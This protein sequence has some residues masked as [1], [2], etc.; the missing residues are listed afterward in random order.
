[1][2]KQ[3][4][5]KAF[6]LLAFVFTLSITAPMAVVK[7]Q[8]T[9]YVYGD[10]NGDGTVNAADVLLLRKYM[11]NYNYDTGE[12]TVVLGPPSQSCKHILVTDP[13]VEP[14]FTTTGLTEGSHCGLCGIVFVAQN[15][16]PV[17]PSK[18]TLTSDTLSIEGENINGNV[19]YATD[20]FVF[21]NNITVTNN[22]SWTV[23]T[24]IYGMQT[25]TTKIVPLNEG[26]NIFYIHITNPDQTVSI[27]N[28]NIYRNHLYTVSFNTNGGTSVSTQYVEEGYL[29]KEPSTSRT[30]YTFVSWD[31]NF[32][33]PITS[34]VTINA[35]WEANKNTP[36]VVEYYLQN[37]EDDNYSIASDETEELTGTTD[38]I[39]TAREKTFSHFTYNPSKSTMSGN[40]DGDGS[41][42][43]KVYYTK[44][45]YT[46]SSA[47]TKGGS[48]IGSGTY[49]Y[50]TTLTVSAN[51]NIGYTFVGWYN[52]EN[53]IST[54]NSYT[55]TIDK[56]IDIEA[57]FDVK[58][59]MK[60][61]A[62]S[63]TSTTCTITGVK[64]KSI[65]EL[66][67][68]D[69]VTSIS[70]SALSGCSSLES[71]TLPFVGEKKDGTG[72]THF[73]YIF[74]ASSYS[75]NDSY[76]PKSLKT[77]VITGGTSIGDDAFYFCS[78]LTSVYI[79]DLVKWCE[80][81]FSDSS[82]NPFY[83]ANNLYLN[84]ELVTELVIPDSI[85]SINKY[86]FYNCSSLTS[87]TIHDG[88]T[89]IGYEAFYGCGL[90]SIEVES[91]NAKYHSAG[92][93]LIETDSRTLILGSNNSTIPSDGSVKRIGSYAFY[94][95][96][97]LTS[98]TIPDS[99]TS[100][101]DD[102]FYGC[103][104]LTSVTIGNGVTSIGDDAFY[105]CRSLESITLP[106]VGEKKDGTG[107]THFGYIFGASDY[108]YNSSYVPKS[109]K[110]VVITG[111]TSI[112]NRAFSDCSSLT[113]VTIGNGVTSIGYKAFD[114]CSR[115][116]SITFEDTSTWYRTTSSSDWKN[117]TGGTSTN[118]TNPSFSATYFT[119]TSYYYNYYWYKK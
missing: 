78:S 84:G 113:S 86:A 92:N 88:V 65:T 41:L 69:Y 22:S 106:F 44:D 118:V 100:I 49:K 47:N 101:G 97:N 63:S 19:S 71:I 18:A 111:G 15:I 66:V 35:N 90:T 76:V 64:D 95:C 37:L 60:I 6:L 11:A 36:Y 17:L 58:D 1:M 80:F 68:P 10:A 117:K 25:I 50:G 61:F 102:A 14:T 12:S 112:G 99:V 29:A 2:K 38:T 89:S 81:S 53:L 74:G 48:V 103:S 108:S 70:K 30:G 98:I 20:I 114:G 23:S 54:N 107:N 75:Y 56:D 21:A 116:T 73:G 3:A 40:I 39:A 59:E 42:V 110:T 72:N 9:E 34:N 104:S 51:E 27:Y 13:R 33:N 26:N 67:V 82:S 77:V 83:Y 62:F 93:C 8:E 4:I 43:L 115:L 109:L 32:N 16:I 96:S 57:R 7:A 45:R 94:Y 91:G 31:Y 5:I 105:G 24:D 52:D 119:S 55:F 46:V 85:T 28:V 79:T 87:I